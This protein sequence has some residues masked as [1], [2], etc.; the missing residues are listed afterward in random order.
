MKYHAGFRKQLRAKPVATK[1][2]EAH[3]KEDL[4]H[5]FAEFR[6]RV[7]KIGIQ[8][9]DIYNLDETGFQIGVVAGEK[10]V[11]VIATLGATGRLAPPMNIFKGEYHLR[12]N[13]DNDMDP[14]ILWARSESGS[15]ND[16]LDLEYHENFDLFTRDKTVRAFRLLICGGH[17]SHLT[18][19]F[20]DFCWKLYICS[21]LPPPHFTHGLQPL[22]VGIFSIWKHNFERAV[23][24]EVFLR[25][26]EI[27][28]ADFFRFFQRFYA[29]SVT[30]DIARSAFCKSGLAPSDSS[31]ALKKLKLCGEDLGENNLAGSLYEGQEFILPPLHRHKGIVFTPGMSGQYLQICLQERMDTTTSSVDWILLWMGN[32]LRLQFEG[33]RRSKSSAQRAM[34]KGGLAS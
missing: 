13:F 1:R 11:L 2:R 20:V 12:N 9:D 17:G 7:D 26:T 23:R 30:P 6:R 5:H 22:D 25:A 27:K 15:T 33:L 3:P 29:M 14:D 34:L 28:K 21:V 19:S 18:Q 24:R 10:L 31:H 4:E 8:A 16:R 32:L